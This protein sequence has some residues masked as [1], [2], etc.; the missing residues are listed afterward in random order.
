MRYYK[1]T[2]ALWIVLLLSC[3]A[4]AQPTVLPLNTNTDYKNATLWLEDN[5]FIYDSLL[6]YDVPPN[7]A[8]AIVFPELMRFSAL[9]NKMEVTGLMV[10]YTRLGKD[11]AD[12]S[13]G[14]FQMKPSFVRKLEID[15][16]AYLSQNEIDR[17]CPFLLNGKDV[18][19]VRKKRVN[20]LTQVR[21]EVSYL[22]L[23]YKICLKRFKNIHF[24]NAANRIRFLATAY[25][26]GYCHSAKYI[27]GQMKKK[28][29][30]VYNGI[31]IRHVNYAVLS[32]EWWK[33]N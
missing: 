15:A 24:K 8:I 11:Y 18:Q 32:L 25:N 1:R 4:R 6:A 17:I 19:E 13:V 26:C 28:Q 21:N 9:R 14:R 16:K 10:L 3:P 30:P 27:L 22:A 31:L 23:F 5:G 12:F 33:E 29:F 2:L 7:E 20:S